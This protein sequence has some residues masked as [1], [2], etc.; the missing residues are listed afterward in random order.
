M[1]ER[2]QLGLSA[3]GRIRLHK[4]LARGDGVHIRY[5]DAH[6]MAPRRFIW[7]VPTRKHRAE[8]LVLRVGCGRGRAQCFPL[9]VALPAQ[10]NA[11]TL[12]VLLLFFNE[13]KKILM[14]VL[15]MVRSVA[16]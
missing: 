15:Y 3:P 16:S 2:R 14:C 10:L 9:S 12:P 5:I 8:D 11:E 1:L 4:A 13:N 6:D 7:G